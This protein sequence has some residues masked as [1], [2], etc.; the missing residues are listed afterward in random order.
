MMAVSLTAF[1]QKDTDTIPVKVYPVSLVKLIVKD[2]M[3]GDSAR[4]LLVLTEKQLLSTEKIISMKD[5]VIHAMESKEKDYKNIIKAKDEQFKIIE[6]HSKKL[7]FQLKKEKVKNKFKSIV[8]Y[9]VIGV[10]T[11]LIISK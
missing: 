1:S 3:R 5:S 10:L 6:D 2:L 11:F 9:G 4:D 8:G 7:T